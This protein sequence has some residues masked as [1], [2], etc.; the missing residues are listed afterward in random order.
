MSQMLVVTINDYTHSV[1]PEEGTIEDAYYMPGHRQQQL[2]HLQEATRRC[3]FPQKRLSIIHSVLTLKKKLLTMPNI[4]Q[5]FINSNSP[6]KKLRKD[7]SSTNGSLLKIEK[8]VPLVGS[9][10]IMTRFTQGRYLRHVHLALRLSNDWWPARPQDWGRGWAAR[11][12]S[13]NHSQETKR[14]GI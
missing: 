4:S 11:Q 12:D 6:H 8:V 7:A 13:A 14:P 1:D 9:C 2:L 3:F 10:L 5:G